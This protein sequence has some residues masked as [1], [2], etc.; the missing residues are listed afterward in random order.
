MGLLVG[1][2]ITSQTLFAATTAARREFAVLEAL[3]IPRWRI[4][5]AVLKQSLCVG[6]LGVVIAM[7]LTVPMTYLVELLGARMLFPPWLVVAATLA[8]MAT[9][10]T[11]GLVALRSLRFTRARRP[12]ALSSFCAELVG[13]RAWRPTGLNLI[14]FAESPWWLRWSQGRKILC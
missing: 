13:C 14:V 6:G 2:V 4:A 3:G 9:A 11:A 12:A 7:V 10:V 8:T 1:L 5:L